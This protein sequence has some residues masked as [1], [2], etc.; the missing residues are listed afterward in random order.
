M[1]IK[2]LKFTKQLTALIISASLVTASQAVQFVVATSWEE[3]QTS[4][5][6]I[7][8]KEHHSSEIK[9]LKAEINHSRAGQQ[10]LYFSD[11]SSLG[12]QICKYESTI[13]TSVT[14]NFDNQ[15]VKMSRWC[16]KYIDSD[17]YYLDLTP[18]TERGHNYVVDLFKKSINPVN[19][20]YDN[21]IMPFSV[22][23]FTK[24]W[25]SAG[26]NAI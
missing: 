21:D 5:A 24:A 16:K 18:E 2:D 13:P 11:L 7:N 3:S 9:T 15:A 6:W 17:N 4:S 25:N 8:Y 19:I 22:V 1:E 12:N 20:K 23:G 14:M 10:R 26:G